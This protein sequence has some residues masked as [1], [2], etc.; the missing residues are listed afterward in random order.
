MCIALG[1]LKW[2]QWLQ[3]KETVQGYVKHCGGI[4]YILTKMFAW[5]IAVSI[6]SIDKER[7]LSVIA[8]RSDG[9]AMSENLKALG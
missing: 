2:G 3:T 5:M 7:I 4:H 1:S 8:A 6:E 9:T